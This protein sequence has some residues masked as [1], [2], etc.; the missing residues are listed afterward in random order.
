MYHIENTTHFYQSIFVCTFVLEVYVGNCIKRV[1]VK[2]Q[3]LRVEENKRCLPG[4]QVGD[5]PC[6]N[7][8]LN[9]DCS[10]E[11]GDHQKTG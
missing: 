11:Y 8:Q 5:R 10:Q 1:L 9:A 4:T 3:K 7:R 6:N 2:L